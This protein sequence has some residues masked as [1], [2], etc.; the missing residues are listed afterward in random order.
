MENPKTAIDALL[1]NDVE[2]GG[3]TIRKVTAGRYALLELVESPFVDF[4]KK[5]TVAN[6][7]PSLFICE[8]PAE[9]LRKYNAKN[10]EK[11]EEDAMAWAET[12]DIDK[13]GPAVDL[14]LE[15]FKDIMKIAPGTGSAEDGKK[16]PE[17][18]AMTTDSSAQ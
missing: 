14:V 13:L 3:I 8:R 10:I 9:D 15:Q 7:I 11:L 12:I 6:I 16:K 5:F 18:N 1:D 17:E 4:S 2:A